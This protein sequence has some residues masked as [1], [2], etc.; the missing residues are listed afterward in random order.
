[1]LPMARLRMT[2]MISPPK[3]TPMGI[4]RVIS[5]LRTLGLAPATRGP[6]GLPTFASAAAPAMPPGPKPGCWPKPGCPPCRREARSRGA[7]R[8]REAHRR[9]GRLAGRPTAGRRTVTGR[10][11]GRRT[12]RGLPTGGRAVAL[13]RRRRAVAPPGGPPCGGRERAG[14]LGRRR[15]VTRLPSRRSAVAAGLLRPAGGGEVRHLVDGH[16]AAERVDAALRL[17]GRRV[18]PLLRRRRAVALLGRRRSAVR[19]LLRRRRP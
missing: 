12:V 8:N 10:P 1:M 14:L 11:T 17:P 19:R 13:I 3:M 4:S 2:P 9:E 16:G 15:A 18:R 6:M 5:A 7:H